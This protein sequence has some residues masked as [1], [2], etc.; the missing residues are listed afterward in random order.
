MSDI[1]EA[2]QAAAQARTEFD[3]AQIDADLYASHSQRYFAEM[4]QVRRLDKAVLVAA[5]K[6]NLKWQALA[7]A[8]AAGPPKRN[9]VSA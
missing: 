6:L 7:N 9:G 1:G 4:Q 5:K 8:V 3:R 2:R